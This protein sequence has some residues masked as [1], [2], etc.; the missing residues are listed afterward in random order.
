MPKGKE[1]MQ[2]VDLNAIE[3]IE[4][5]SDIDP[6]NSLRYGFP[7][8]SAEGTASSAVVYFE[9]EP[10]KRLSR[11]TDS[12]EELL[13][14][15]EGTAEASVGAEGGRLTAGQIAVVPALEPHEVTN[16]GDG[17]LRAVGLFSAAA[18]VSTFE[19]PTSEGGEQVF[20]IGAPMPLAAPLSEP[21]AQT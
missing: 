9:L 18:V 17:V 4:E 19:Q 7:L 21:A 20:A 3:L 15:L 6:R 13:L 1:E 14:V 10:G 5:T 16:V 12:A 11:H 8:S 2:T